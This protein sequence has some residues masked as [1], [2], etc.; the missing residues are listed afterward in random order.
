LNARSNVAGG[1]LGFAPPR[2]ASVEQGADEKS[3]G[4]D[5]IGTVIAAHQHL[6]A[7]D[8]VSIGWLVDC[9]HHNWIG[10]DQLIP[11]KH[12]DGLSH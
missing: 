9:L 12:I 1:S 4:L 10:S 11:E 8:E 5:V 2:E 6:N 3:G 7:F